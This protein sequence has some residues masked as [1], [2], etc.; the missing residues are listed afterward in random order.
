MVAFITVVTAVGDYA[1]WQAGPRAWLIAAGCFLWALA[2]AGW[3]LVSRRAPLSTSIPIGHV[4]SV[5]LV[6]GM[7][8][9]LNHEKVPWFGVLLAAVAILV[10][11]WSH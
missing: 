1:V 11:S 5:L 6:C 7:A 8:A 10:L 4:S 9:V 2:C 3:V